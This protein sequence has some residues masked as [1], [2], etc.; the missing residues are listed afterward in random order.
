L[1]SPPTYHILYGGHN[2][3]FGDRVVMMIGC[4]LTDI[5][6]NGEAGYVSMIYNS[7]CSV[8]EVKKSGPLVRSTLTH[9]KRKVD[10]MSSSVSKT[11]P[12]W[13]FDNKVSD[14]VHHFGLQGR[15]VSL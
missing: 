6:I 4:L 7:A 1:F 9:S 15:D 11:I 8:G 13:G 2:T 5:P 12:N 14:F 3:V 10:M